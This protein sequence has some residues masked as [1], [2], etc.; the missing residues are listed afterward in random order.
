LM[1]W[2]SFGESELAEVSLSVSSSI[3]TKNII[4]YDGHAYMHVLT[5][6]TPITVLCTS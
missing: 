3:P 1:F 5:S 2:C 6:S 4:Y